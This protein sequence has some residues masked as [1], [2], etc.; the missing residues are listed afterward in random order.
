MVK[1]GEETTVVL[2]V[3]L[4]LPAGGKKLIK[5]S[6]YMY[7][8][9]YLPIYAE[10]KKKKKMINWMKLKLNFIRKGARKIRT[11]GRGE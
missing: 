10:G 9:I 11:S 4:P 5:S 3:L 8:Y 7:I 2:S 1:G 6:I